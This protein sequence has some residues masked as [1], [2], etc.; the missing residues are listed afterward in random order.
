MTAPHPIVIEA[1][2]RR[3]ELGLTH[4]DVHATTG[5]ARSTVRNWDT[6]RRTPNLGAFDAYLRATGFRLAVVPL[7]QPVDVVAGE[8]LPFGELVLDRSEKFCGGCQQARHRSDFH[9][10]RSRGD[11]LSPRCR[12]CVSEK[13]QQQR[14]RRAEREQREVA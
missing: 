10:D 6:G 9:S 13:R 8:Q 2:R 12:W 7:E 14:K 1:A 3:T 5:I 4:D 11:G